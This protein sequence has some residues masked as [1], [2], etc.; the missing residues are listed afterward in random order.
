MKKTIIYLFLAS[1]LFS[2][3]SSL[4]VTSD[5]DKDADFAKFKTFEYY[6]WAKESD[7]HINDI[8]KRRIETA[9]SDEAYERGLSFV[10]ENGDLIITLFI[11]IK[12]ETETTANTSYY[13]GGYGGYY[14]YGPGWGWGPGMGMGYSNTYYSTYD[15]NVGTL[16][17]DVYDKAE[18][19]LIFEA[20]AS[21]TISSNPKKREESIKYIASEM[22]KDYPVKISEE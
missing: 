14:G 10:K 15:Y 21:K 17:I 1:V 7:K 22:M 8:D 13:G 4:S 11:V 18:K 3:C 5:Y 9:F 16:V 19:K 2:S 12:Q 20:R 6:G